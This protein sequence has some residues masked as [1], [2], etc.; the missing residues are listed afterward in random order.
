M[1]E[2]RLSNLI[3][4]ERDDQEAHNLKPHVDPQTRHMMLLTNKPATM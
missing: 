4:K 3:N 1:F 2:Y